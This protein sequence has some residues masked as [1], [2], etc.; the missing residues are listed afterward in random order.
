MNVLL[1]GC[2]AA[3]RKE[4][5]SAGHAGRQI[6]GEGVLDGQG[7]ET[8]AER[9][10]DLRHPSGKAGKALLTVLEVA[11]QLHVRGQ[12]RCH[13]VEAR[14]ALTR[15]GRREPA[16]HLEPAQL[17]EFHL[18]YRGVHPRRARES[19]I[20]VHDGIAV[21][22]RQHVHLD[23]VGAVAHGGAQGSQGVLGRHGAAASVRDYQRSHYFTP[24]VSAVGARR[25]WRKTKATRI[26]A[27]TKTSAA[28]TWFHCV[29]WE[30]SVRIMVASPMGRVRTFAEL[31]TMSGQKKSL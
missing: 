31:V 26:G 25:R 1:G 22:A 12:R 29:P 14:H 23:G 11:D 4:R 6:E 3:K 28:M 18:P 13:V 21:A 30:P 15:E 27:I 10:D 9:A 17:G 20:V 2:R 5:G 24:V 8:G 16:A 19:V 7:G